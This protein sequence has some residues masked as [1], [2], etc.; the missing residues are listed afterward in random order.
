MAS[1]ELR[2]VGL[3]SAGREGH[4][5]HDGHGEHSG[6]GGGKFRLNIAKLSPVGQFQLSPI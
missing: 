6:C 2:E 1:A 4:R 5:G 3:V